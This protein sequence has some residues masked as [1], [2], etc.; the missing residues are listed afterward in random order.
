M[1]CRECKTTV[2]ESEM[3][4]GL[5]CE[6]C[7]KDPDVRENVRLAKNPRWKKIAAAITESS[8]REDKR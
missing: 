5:V 6:R 8:K 2:R 1:P 4:D 3:V 7:Y